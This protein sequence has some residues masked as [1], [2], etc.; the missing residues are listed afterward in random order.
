MLA[1]RTVLLAQGKARVGVQAQYHT[2]D[3]LDGVVVQVQPLPYPVP[4]LVHEIVVAGAQH[5]GGLLAEA[6]MGGSGYLQQETFL[7]RAGTDARR[8]KLPQDVQHLLQLAAVG[9]QVL[10]YLGLISQLVERLG[11]HAVLAERP[12]QV[13]EHLLLMGCEVVFMDLVFQVVIEG[14]R[15]AVI[16]VLGSVLCSGAI[17]QVVGDVVLGPIVAHALVGNA[18][19]VSVQSSGAV[20]VSLCAH[21][22]IAVATGLLQPGILHA[23]VLHPLTK[24]IHR[25]LRQLGQ[26]HLLR[27]QCLHLH[28]LLALL[29]D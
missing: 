18:P 20:A 8:I 27:S 7:Q 2:L 29:L 10:V 28:L 16:H 14:E 26:E 24:G 5:L 1:G 6:H 12:Y 4:S 11:Q 15:G 19:A 3:T 25:H 21:G 17:E 9:G 13:L 23:L 22:L